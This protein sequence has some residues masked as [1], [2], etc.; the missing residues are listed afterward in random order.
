VDFYCP[1][2]RLAV[3]VDGDVHDSRGDYDR[4]RDHVLLELGVQ[5]LRLRNEEVLND[6]QDCVLRSLCRACAARAD[7]RSLSPDLGGKGWG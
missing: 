7:G 3:E 5:V 2:L 4:A 1:R 6:T